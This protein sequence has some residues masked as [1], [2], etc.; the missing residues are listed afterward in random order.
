MQHI[1]SFTKP[2][3]MLMSH[4]IWLLCNVPKCSRKQLD[5][6]ICYNTNLM[7]VS[8]TEFCKPSVTVWCPTIWKPLDYTLEHILFSQKSTFSKHWKTFWFQSY[9]CGSL[10]LNDNHD[11]SV[12]F[13]IFSTHIIAY[14][15]REEY[16]SS[17]KVHVCFMQSD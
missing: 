13:A 9:F 16:V 4:F 2:L 11:T 6:Y 12:S 5:P 8:S 3:R 17:L 10:W 7:G 14:D 15:C 1:K